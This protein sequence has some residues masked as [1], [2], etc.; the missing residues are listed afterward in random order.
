MIVYNPSNIDIS[1]WY[2]NNNFIIKADDVTI[3]NTFKISSDLFNKKQSFNIIP[4]FHNGYLYFGPNQDDFVLNSSRISTMTGDMCIIESPRAN[5]SMEPAIYLGRN[6]R[7]LNS[8]VYL[9]FRMYSNNV[10]VSRVP[11]LVYGRT[12]NHKKL[13]F[14]LSDTLEDYKELVYDLKDKLYLVR[15]NQC[16]NFKLNYNKEHKTC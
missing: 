1:S 9:L 2:V 8:E 15:T 12:I 11:E 3:V 4:I 14:E 13:N 10:T 7:D 6:K 16:T 5:I